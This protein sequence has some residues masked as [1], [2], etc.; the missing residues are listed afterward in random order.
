MQQPDPERN[1][2]TAP[3][4][5]FVRNINGTKTVVARLE[6][7]DPSPTSPTWLGDSNERYTHASSSV[8]AGAALPSGSTLVAQRLA[9]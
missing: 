8:D 4:T 7:E 1:K 5:Y 6:S 9:N 2:L 3:Y